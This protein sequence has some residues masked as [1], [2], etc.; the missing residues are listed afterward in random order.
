MKMHMEQ[1]MEKIIEAALTAADPKRALLK[2]LSSADNENLSLSHLRTLGYQKFHIISFGKAAIPMA[3]GLLSFCGEEL[4]GGV[5]IPKAS[6]LMETAD[7]HRRF[8]IVPSAHPVPDERSSEAGETILSYLSNLTSNDF[9]FYLISGGGSSLVT[10]PEPGIG[11]K[12]I[13]NVNKLLLDCGASINEINGI[14]KHIDQIKGG[15][16]IGKT[17]P[18]GFC[19]LILSDVLGDPVDVIASGPTV[20]DPSTF[21]EA[22]KTIEK[23]GLQEEMP[24]NV[25]QFLQEGLNGLQVE[26]PK[27]ALKNQKIVAPQIIGSN[28]NSL[29]SAAEAA[30]KL[31][32]I[33]VLL[34]D[35]LE[36]EARLA[37]EWIVKQARA[38]LLESNLECKG[39]CFLAGGETTVTIKGNGKGGRNLELALSVV[40]PLHTME[41]TFF[42]AFST[43]GED[44]PTDAAG[45]WVDKHS[46]K[47]AGQLGLVV[48]EYLD[49]NDSYPFF[50]RM[51][52]LIRTGSTGTNVNDICFL[53]VEK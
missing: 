9:V 38:Y 36:G 23:Y 29:K 45:A 39:M 27:T 10:L 32:L 30:S 8:A 7:W 41:N 33:P 18:A 37:G 5:I 14:R 42:C 40:L 17:Y 24:K 3:E 19:T 47:K 51:E 15:K 34:S 6:Y 31:G 11:L 20:F 1:F 52:Q 43:D 12:D 4:A 53:I 13:Q 16:L 28:R 2:L 26:T 49:R 22:W 48:D 21:Q 35:H 46:F 44:G 50:E 25:N